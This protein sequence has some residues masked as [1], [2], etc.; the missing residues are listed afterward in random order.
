MSMQKIW[1]ASWEGVLGPGGARRA[2]RTWM[3]AH[4]TWLRQIQAPDAVD[5]DVTGLFL[6]IR[7]TPTAWE[8]DVPPVRRWAHRARRHSSA[9]TPVAGKPAS[10]SSSR[11]SGRGRSSASSSKALRSMCT[12]AASH[13]EIIKSPPQPPQTA[14]DRARRRRHRRGRR[15]DLAGGGVARTLPAAYISCGVNNPVETLELVAAERTCDAV[16]CELDWWT[17]VGRLA[18]LAGR[19][20][21]R[22]LKQF[23]LVT[24]F[25]LCKLAGWVERACA[26]SASSRKSRGGLTTTRDAHHTVFP[27]LRDRR[28][29]RGTRRAREPQPLQ[30]TRCPQNG[31]LT[32]VGASRHTTHSAASPVGGFLRPIMRL[33]ADRIFDGRRTRRLSSSRRRCCRRARSDSAA[34]VWTRRPRSS[35]IQGARA[36]P[37]QSSPSFVCTTVVNVPAG[38]TGSARSVDALPARRA[39][40]A[41]FSRAW[42][43]AG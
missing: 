39:L 21:C 43:G 29:R 25:A 26:A 13:G 35:R 4:L 34:R 3:A 18:A 15:G 42:P 12:N 1:S 28:D 40:R 11:G 9:R 2:R 31:S 36:R 16:A 17:L 24:V 33:N 7:T 30:R 32:P 5:R 20:A 14:P 27:P 10:A 41:P 37:S 19:W 8:Q 6:C 22:P 23:A 38:A